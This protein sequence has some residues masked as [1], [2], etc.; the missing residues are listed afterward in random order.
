MP[1]FDRVD[2]PISRIK[3]ILPRMLFSN[4]E[5]K[6]VWNDD[7]KE[8]LSK[9]AV[10]VPLVNK[11]AYCVGLLYYENLY[12]HKKIDDEKKKK[13]NPGIITYILYILCTGHLNSG[14]SNAGANES[15]D[16]T[17]IYEEKRLQKLD[18][19]QEESDSK[20]EA[21]SSKLKI[22]LT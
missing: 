2:L 15:Q 9:T 19:V 7:G 12:L 1:D 8:Y 11:Y 10:L 22:N 4:D 14:Q 6:I 21:S 18:S 17:Q 3:D 5:Y 20:E 13:N 16:I